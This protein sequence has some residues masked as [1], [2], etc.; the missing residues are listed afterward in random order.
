MTKEITVEKEAGRFYTPT[1]IVN[2][3]LD[4]SGYCGQ[5]ILNKHV[6][7]NSCGDGAFLCQIVGRYCKE[8]LNLSQNREAL[9]KSLE[10]YIHG[11]EI[12]IDEHK[13][14]VE[15]LSQVAREFD[16]YNVK[17]DV[18]CADAT[19]V[20]IFN[21]KMDFVL[22]N[23]PYV[24]VH[25][26]GDNFSEIKRFSFAQNG[27]TDLFI[28]FY[29]LGIRM[30]S[31]KGVLGYITPSSYF[32]SIA[33]SCMRQYLVENNLLKAVVDLQHF[34][35]FSAT[36]YTVITILQNNRE[37]N[38]TDYYRYNKEELLPY[39]VE[40]LTPS[41]YYISGDFYFSTKESLSLLKKINCNCGKTDISVKNGYATLCDSVFIS[42]FD[43]ESP[44]IISAVKAS[45][46]IVRRIF[47]PYDQ[48]GFLIDEEELKKDLF[49]YEYLV[50]NKEKLLKRSNEKSG[51]KYWYAFGRS[52]AIRDTFSDKMAINS[53]LRN[54]E[55]WKFT[56]APANTGVYGGLYIV[57]KTISFE[58]IANVLRSKE[59][60]SYIS[61]LGKYKQG[62][63]YTFSS[64]DVKKFLDYKF[65]YDRRSH[66]E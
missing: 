38:G 9:K 8:F 13:K 22:G 48:N 31:D 1:F 65:A 23:P 60:L 46:G 11:I 51:N 39:Y 5:G 37:A 49:L 6:I 24:R 57:S 52:Q 10:T 35:A 44:Y 55:D 61:I 4:L 17:W 7:D 18:L 53:L 64:K 28:V 20:E 14:C 30:L 25:N 50:D 40:K 42:D 54:E 62:G 2:N 32:N 43:F 66:V 47:F 21:G 12:D 15:N 45:K 3:I 29:E 58:K 59:F 27:M 36:T 63:Y 19:S 34:Q 56:M 26:L 33:G 41:E 16:V